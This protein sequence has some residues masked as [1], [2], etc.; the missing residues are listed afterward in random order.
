MSTDPGVHIGT[1]G[2]QVPKSVTE[3]TG[4]G[5]H[6]ERYARLFNATEINTTFHR[7]HVPKTFER[8]A[9]MVPNDFRF[10]VKM[11]KSVTHERRLAD[12]RPA[13]EFLNMVGAL[14]GKLGPVLVQL[15]PSLAWSDQASDF[16]SALREVYSG[17]VVL[18]ARNSSWAS[19]DALNALKVNAIASVA[20]DPP[21]LTTELQ[22]GGHPDPVYF[23]LHGSPR[24]YWSSYSDEFLKALAVKVLE[25]SRNGQRVW[26]I[27]DNTAAGAGA[28]NALR[29]KKLLA[30]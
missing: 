25:H 19:P 29:L 28:Q 22:P 1:A 8:W 27:F 24:I 13:Q 9:A 30:H 2:W 16:L 18:E 7:P 10:A 15:P 17:H 21:L 26:V 3:P 20:T 11:S 4:T 23:R 5:S 14:G 6:L 12:I